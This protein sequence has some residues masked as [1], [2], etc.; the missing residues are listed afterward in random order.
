[1]IMGIWNTHLTS[2][3]FNRSMSRWMPSAVRQSRSSGSDRIAGQRGSAADLRSSNLC[4]QTPC[5]AV[6]VDYDEW[7]V[8]LE[9]VNGLGKSGGIRGIGEEDSG[10]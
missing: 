4:C 3:F 8:G 9:I 10:W 5:W 2:P 7:S 6:E 1:M